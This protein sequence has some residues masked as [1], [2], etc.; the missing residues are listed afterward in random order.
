MDLIV[1]LEQGLTDR[2]QLF[3]CD[4]ID[5]ILEHI[6]DFVREA[7]EFE[8]EALAV[9]ERP[10][11]IAQ[12]W[13]VWTEHSSNHW[14]KARWLRRCAQVQ[15]I[16]VVK[17][18]ETRGDT[19]VTRRCALEDQLADFRVEHGKRSRALEG[20]VSLLPTINA[21]FDRIC[22]TTII[23]VFKNRI[24]RTAELTGLYR[25]AWREL[26]KLCAGQC[27]VAQGSGS[28]DPT[29]RPCVGCSLHYCSSCSDT[30]R[31]YFESEAGCTIGY[32]R[33]FRLCKSVICLR[34][35]VPAVG[36]LSIH[37]NQWE[38]ENIEVLWEAALR[39]ESREERQRIGPIQRGIFLPGQVPLPTD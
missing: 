30:P 22:A 9:Q 8:E 3:K 18:L 32:E 21:D 31:R 4:D 29:T 13:Q 37:Q 34:C 28:G 23:R 27:V 15:R 11:S 10:H 7:S 26:E 20:V 16:R 6:K 17:L 36:G 14:R 12:Y 25:R 1:D 35:S 2:D 38:E 24:D 39:C 33:A 5:L 19:W